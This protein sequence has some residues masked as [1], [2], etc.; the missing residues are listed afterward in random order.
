[1]RR[2]A[3][4]ESPMLPSARPHLLRSPRPAPR[5]AVADGPGV[6]PALTRNP[7]NGED[8]SLR[9]WS[10]ARVPPR[11]HSALPQAASRWARMLALCLSLVG[12][13]AAAEEEG[14]PAALG[15]QFPGEPAVEELQRAA[16][17]EAGLEPV[18]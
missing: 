15:C 13:V 3:A 1:M 5:P 6:S 7:W 14:D 2:V 9:R 10:L 16:V 4:V 8:F 18:R 11:L 17:R 12:A